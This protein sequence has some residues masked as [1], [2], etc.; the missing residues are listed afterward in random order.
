MRGEDSHRNGSSPKY[1]AQG[2]GTIS[3]DPSRRR[4]CGA[5]PCVAVAMVA[6][7]HLR[8]FPSLAARSIGSWCA[9]SDEW[10]PKVRMQS[11][12][13]HEMIDVALVTHR[14]SSDRMGAAS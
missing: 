14:W 3:N 11:I 6:W 13:F 8:T 12:T 5:F 9:S 7:V 2:V 4:I 10:A 1:M